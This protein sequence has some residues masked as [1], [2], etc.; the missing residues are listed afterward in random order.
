M[1]TYYWDIDGF[2]DASEVRANCISDLLAE[3]ILDPLYGNDCEKVD[4]EY[5]IGESSADKNPRRFKVNGHME[6]IKEI[7]RNFK[8]EN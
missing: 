1:K 7:L 3:L 2:E 4:I 8:D 5:W 6:H